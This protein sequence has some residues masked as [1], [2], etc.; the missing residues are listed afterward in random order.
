M[1]ELRLEQVTFDYPDGTRALDRVDL[2]VVHHDLQADLGHEV[3]LVLRSSV[4]L[5]VAALAA[6]AADFAH[7]DAGD[8]G[9][10]ERIFDVLRDDVDILADH[11]HGC[12]PFGTSY[13]GLGLSISY[14][15][16][17]DDHGGL[18][19]VESVPEKGTRFMIK[20]PFR[21]AKESERNKSNRRSNS[22]V[23]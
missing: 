12:A 14:Y 6:E 18:M 10:L 8:A 9:L 19:S 4:G 20:L 5:G 15:I 16:I 21:S 17:V 22:A 23:T 13:A 1:S 7:G 11:I 3:D 2:V